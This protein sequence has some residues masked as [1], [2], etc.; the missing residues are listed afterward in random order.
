VPPLKV[1][2]SDNSA[3]W[4]ALGAGALIVVAASDKQRRRSGKA[5]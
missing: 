1:P 3:L 2:E 5:A 4:L